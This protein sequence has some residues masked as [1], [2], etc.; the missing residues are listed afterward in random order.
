MVVM[1]YSG[2]RPVDRFQVYRERLKPESAPP[3]TT[4][5]PSPPGTPASTPPG[6]PFSETD[7]ERSRIT[8]FPPSSTPFVPPYVAPISDASRPVLSPPLSSGY[9]QTSDDLDPRGVLFGMSADEILVLTLYAALFVMFCRK[10]I[11]LVRSCRRRHSA[12]RQQAPNL[13]STWSGEK[14]QIFLLIC[15]VRKVQFS[16][17]VIRA[18]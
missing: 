1:L 13:N 5:G 8:P 15:K 9:N 6:T 4:A 2:V 17:F 18:F 3:P 14:V 10:M 11:E 12:S 7:V 16:L